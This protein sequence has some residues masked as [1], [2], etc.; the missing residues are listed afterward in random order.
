MLDILPKP[1][2]PNIFCLTFSFLSIRWVKEEFS[3][4]SSLS[5]NAENCHN[6]YIRLWKFKLYLDK[7]HFLPRQLFAGS[8][9]VI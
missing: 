8:E 1:E 2:L 3:V 7:H 6:K 5:H 4:R 9:M